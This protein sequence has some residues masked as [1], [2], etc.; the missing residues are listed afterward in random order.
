MF[1]RSH[2]TSLMAFL[3]QLIEKAVTVPVC[4]LWSW[5]CYLEA[6]RNPITKQNAKTCKKTDSPF[7]AI[8]FGKG[9]NEGRVQVF[10]VTTRHW[11]VALQPERA[12]GRSDP[13]MQ[14]APSPGKLRNSSCC[15]RAPG[16][17]HTG[18]SLLLPSQRGTPGRQNR[19]SF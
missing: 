15:S 6:D 19:S 8:F 11:R 17:P 18:G 12:V 4:Y 2:S 14:A 10:R 13:A 9:E 3:M 7:P 16:L 1:W 5:F